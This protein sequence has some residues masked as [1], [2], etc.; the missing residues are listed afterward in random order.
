MQNS[1][2]AMALA[3]IHFSKVVALPAAVLACGT[4]FLHQYLFISLKKINNNINIGDIMEI[5]ARIK[6]EESYI[7][8]SWNKLFSSSW[9]K[10]ML[11]AMKLEVLFMLQSS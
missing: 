10:Q 4:I 8:Y 11:M 7:S 1:G 6:L 3:V 9:N 2:L 5:S